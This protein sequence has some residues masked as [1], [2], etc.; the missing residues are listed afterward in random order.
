MRIQEPKRDTYK[1][2]KYLN[3]KQL[4]THGLIGTLCACEVRNRVTNLVVLPSQVHIQTELLEKNT[5]NNLI[6][7]SVVE[8]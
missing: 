4:F 5:Q 2:T 8:T 3:W 7:H 1:S 6:C